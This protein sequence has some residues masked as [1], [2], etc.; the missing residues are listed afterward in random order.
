MPP[1][2]TPNMAV[3]YVSAPQTKAEAMALVRARILAIYDGGETRPTVIARVIGLSYPIVAQ[4]LH[5]NNRAI[6]RSGERKGV[7][8]QVRLAEII[9]LRKDGKS[10]EEIGRR[11]GITRAR[12]GQLVKKHANDPALLGP[13][14]R[15]PLR[16]ERHCAVCGAITLH[17]PSVAPKS[18]Y[19]SPRCSGVARTNP[20]VMRRNDTALDLRLAGHSWTEI[21][22]RLGF[23]NQY[24]TCT[25]A[26]RAAK[27]RGIKL[28]RFLSRK[29]A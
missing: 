29:V 27:R 28:A 3:E 4:V 26:H 21:A 17:K 13:R 25:A 1:F 10:Y 22:T 8:D 24:V 2:P 14:H 12:V 18:R 9:A 5:T 23:S 15:A 16:A 6:K 19:C 7:R 20:D 11:F